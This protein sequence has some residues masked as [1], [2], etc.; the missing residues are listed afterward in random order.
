MIFRGVLVLLSLATV[1]ATADDLRYERQGDTPLRDIY[2]SLLGN[3]QF[4]RSYAVVIGV[5]DYEA[6][7][8][9]SAPTHDAQRMREFLVNEAGFDYVRMLTDADATRDQILRLMDTE[10]PNRVGPDDRFL[11]YFS[12]H[13][14][15]RELGASKRGYL[16]LN[17]SRPGDWEKM[18]DMP[19]VKEWAENLSGAR[20][21]LFVLDACFSG[22]A[23]Y[24]P[25]T[26]DA[27]RATKERLSRPS[28]Y[29]LTAGVDKEESFAI[30]D[31]SLFTQA[32]LTVARGQFQPPVDGIVSLEDMIP[33][34]NRYIDEKTE[35]LGGHIRMTPQLY[36]ERIDNNE[37]EF[38]FVLPQVISRP[39]GKANVTQPPE[40]KGNI[41][42][43]PTDRQTG[44]QDPVGAQSNA[45]AFPALPCQP[46]FQ[47]SPALR[48]AQSSC[49][50]FWPIGGQ[51]EQQQS[52]D[53]RECQQFAVE[54][55][56]PLLPPLVPESNDQK[57]LAAKDR[58]LAALYDC[59]RSRGYVAAPR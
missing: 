9:L 20:Q 17:K 11:F 51:S 4:R 50:Y 24:Q 35:E 28:S 16:L 21:V 6:F 8:K 42:A 41:P 57:A 10:L 31:S 45:G 53:T 59:M 44:N 47:P 19:R 13:G 7:K 26:G 3:G 27:L 23:A 40:K 46:R 48:G 12:G 39:A 58:L 15:T 54:H 43:P 25:K 55:H 49:L 22:L 5:G 29:I 52:Q 36:K 37:G 38:F 18:I 30:G 14:A 34:I 2:T 56:N 1:S 32:F 33:R